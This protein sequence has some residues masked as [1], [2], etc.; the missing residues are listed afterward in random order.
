[1]SLECFADRNKLSLTLLRLLQVHLPPVAHAVMYAVDA[2][3]M[4]V[5]PK[6]TR[7]HHGEPD[8]GISS[9]LSTTLTGAITKLVDKSNPCAALVATCSIETCSYALTF[10]RS[11]HV[12]DFFVET[13]L[14]V[15]TVNTS[16]FC[17]LLLFTVWSSVLV[18]ITS[19]CGGRGH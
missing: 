15:R 6:D 9:T 10:E 14:T 11:D 4:R 8:P 5:P 13:Q 7:S 12:N 17:M 2:L 1:M 19:L 16:A 3:A 18:G